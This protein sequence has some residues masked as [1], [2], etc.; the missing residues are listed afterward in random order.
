[1]KKPIKKTFEVMTCETGQHANLEVRAS[2]FQNVPFYVHYISH[3][4]ILVCPSYAA[5]TIATTARCWRYDLSGLTSC[6]GECWKSPWSRRDLLRF[7]RFHFLLKSEQK[8]SRL[9]LKHGFLV[10]LLPTII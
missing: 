1:M 8:T 9:Q 7:Y 5:S 4:C 6:S 3:G 10:F 2:L